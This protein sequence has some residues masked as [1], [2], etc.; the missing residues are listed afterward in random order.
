MKTTNLMAEHLMRQTKN[1]NVW[2]AV[3]MFCMWLGWG[4]S[5]ALAV[6]AAGRLP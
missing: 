2:K 5:Y 1:A 3:E 4:E 6:E